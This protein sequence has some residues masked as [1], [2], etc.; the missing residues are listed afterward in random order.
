M[1]AP[2]RLETVRSSVGGGSSV[3]GRPSG[4]GGEVREKGGEIMKGRK[5]GKGDL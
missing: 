4:G 2:I 1:E 3:V 5:R